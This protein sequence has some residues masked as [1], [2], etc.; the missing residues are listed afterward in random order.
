ML[1]GVDH[2]QPGFLQDLHGFFGIA[3]LQQ[4]FHNLLHRPKILLVGFKY[5]MRERRSLVPI[6]I[7]EIQVEE[8]LCLLT[9]FLEIG[10]LFQKLG[11]LGDIALGRM[12]PCFDDY[13]G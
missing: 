8:E 10:G 13:C 4:R 9:A 7:L 11:G 12:R 2:G 3:G 5:A 1:S 6:G